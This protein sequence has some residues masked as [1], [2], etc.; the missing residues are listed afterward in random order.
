VQQ[1]NTVRLAVWVLVVASALAAADTPSPELLLKDGRVDD[2]IATLN[3]RL[4][5]SAQDAEA[6]NLLSR[7]YYAVGKSDDAIRTGEKAV[8]LA[9]NSAEYHLWLGRAYGQ[10]AENCNPVFCAPGMARKMRAEFERAVQLNGDDFQARTDL[11]EFY[12]DAPGIVGGGTDKAKR[13]VATIAKQ[14]A[15]TGHWVQARLSEKEGDFAGAEKEFKAAIEASGGRSNNWLSLASFYRRRGRLAEMEDAI[16]KAVNAQKK[17]TNLFFEAGR[18]LYRAGRNFPQAA[19]LMG[20]YLAGKDKSEDAPAFEAHYILGQIYEKQGNKAE[21][22]KEY[23]AALA[24]ARE[25][26]QARE[27]LAKLGR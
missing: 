8:A 12:I 23:Q 14:D 16:T 27:A 13:E 21:A 1:R 22:A 20:K 11:A 24:L 26:K 15:A 19:Q 7:A 4:S 10:K 5:K 25:Y 6:Y 9:P 3:S 2:A 18:L 17:S